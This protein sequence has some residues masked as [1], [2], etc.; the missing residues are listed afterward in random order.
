MRKI[1]VTLCVIVPMAVSAAPAEAQLQWHYQTNYVGSIV[2]YTIAPHSGLVGYSPPCPPDFPVLTGG[3]Y[4]NSNYGM[5]AAVS[6]PNGTVWQVDMYNNTRSLQ[7]FWV[8]GVC[9]QITLTS[10]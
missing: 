2:P 6:R 1:L 9:L 4:A 10:G 5:W 7:D 8:Y 3:G